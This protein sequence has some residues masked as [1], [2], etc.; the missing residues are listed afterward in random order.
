MEYK[1]LIVDDEPDIVDLLS[2]NLS[3]EGYN[4]Q[5]AVDGLDC[6]QK[7][8]DLEPHLIIL[9]IMMPNLDGIETARRIKKIKELQSTVILFLTARSEEYTE[10]TAFEVGADDFISKP[11]KPKAL[12]HRVQA[13][14]KRGKMPDAKL[15]GQ[16]AISDIFINPENYCITKADGTQVVLPRKE[17]QLFHFLSQHPNKVFD[18]DMLLQ[19]VWKKDMFVL[20]RTVDV[21]IRKVREKIGEKYIKTLKGV[22]YM[23]VDE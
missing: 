21:H 3:N 14:L 18:R 17:F 11:I 6:L 12:I 16:L 2:Y 5:T 13:L 19:K 22:G 8:V 15:S 4:V 7:A 23:F 20:D 10:I 9:D 1:I